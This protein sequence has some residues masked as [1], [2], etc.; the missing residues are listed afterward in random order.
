MFLLILSLLVC[1]PAHANGSLK[2]PDSLKEKWG[3]V[4][5]TA[6]ENYE[7]VRTSD[8]GVSVKRKAVEARNSHFVKEVFAKAGDLWH[9][10][11]LKGKSLLVKAD[12]KM[13]EAVLDK[14]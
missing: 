1:D 4:K 10:A 8:L 7:R 9:R 3:E 6:V 14:E 2:A 13:H 12:R 11:L 5:T